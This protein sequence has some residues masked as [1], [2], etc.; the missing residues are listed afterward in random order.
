MGNARDL[1]SFAVFSPSYGGKG[2]LLTSTMTAS[3]AE[4]FTHVMQFSKRALVLG[5]QTAGSVEGAAKHPLPGGG[6][7]M[8]AE[9]D[10][11][12]LDEQRLQRRGVTPDRIIP[13]RADDLRAG[14]DP[15]LDAALSW[16]QKNISG[17]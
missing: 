4:I 12:G 14:R 10:Y 6:Y 17:D 2:V 8:I 11:I 13:L 1:R 7:I 5:G 15:G 3:S 16:L 9:R